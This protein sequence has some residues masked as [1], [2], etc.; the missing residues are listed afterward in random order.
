MKKF[1]ILCLLILCNF[2]IVTSDVKAT[3]DEELPVI[4]I[5]VDVETTQY[6]NVSIPL[7][8]QLGTIC[9]DRRPC[10]LQLMVKR[11]KE[12][13]YAATFFLNVYEYKRYGEKPIMRIAKWL[14][15]SGQ[16]VQLHTHP[17]WAYDKKRNLM[18]QYSLKEQ[19]RIIRDGKE[20]LE[21]WVGKRIIAHR[22][23]AYGADQNTLEALIK[24]DI[25]YDSSLFFTNSNCQINSLP[26]KKN[27]LSMYGPLYEFPVT[28]YKKIESS[29]ISPR[30]LKSFSR[31]RKYDI[32]WFS[33]QSEAERAMQ[34]TIEMKMDFVILFLHSFSFI[35]GYHTN[36][37][38]EADTDAIEIFKKLIDFINLKGM[39]VLTFREIRKQNIELNQHLN[40][41]DFIP[42]ISLQIGMGQYLRKFIGMNRDNYI[43][44]I[45]LFSISF[46]LLIL[47]AILIIS[48]LRKRRY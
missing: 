28:V 12:S 6:N 14:D 47:V 29:S 38:N 13:G 36:G 32:N 27:V 19:T 33:N 30:K 25:F 35:K 22:A 41:P 23:G 24:N 8:D 20:L 45:L 44:F 26:L 2:L 18:H 11:L 37:E 10:G 1:L 4:I 7:P 46:I 40:T 17:Q 42:E 48:H 3:S 15:D 43:T 16:D 34:K 21:K 31:I 5:T 9:Q 39:R